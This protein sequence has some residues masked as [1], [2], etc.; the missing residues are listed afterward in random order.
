MI[1]TSFVC[2]MLVLQ[3][4][5]IIVIGIPILVSVWR[6]QTVSDAV[7]DFSDLKDEDGKVILVRLMQ[8]ENGEWTMYR[9]TIRPKN[10][11]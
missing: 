11:N 4:L 9:K 1:P 3:T 7:E 2:L 8:D 10:K 6:L 5:A